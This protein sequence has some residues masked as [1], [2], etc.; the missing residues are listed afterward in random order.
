MIVAIAR[1]VFSVIRYVIRGGFTRSYGRISLFREVVY[2]R[3]IIQHRTRQITTAYFWLGVVVVRGTRIGLRRLG[4]TYIGVVM[5]RGSSYARHLRYQGNGG[6][7]P[8]VI[9]RNGH[10]NGVGR[11]SNQG[12][13]WGILSV[14]LI[15]II[16]RRQPW[17]VLR[18]SPVAI[19]NRIWIS[20]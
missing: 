20:R 8:R 7:M 2:V 12:K 14:G 17:V 16:G 19:V 13:G 6:I 3:G 4:G 1:V 5:G 9:Q 11:R 18:I 15:T 10:E